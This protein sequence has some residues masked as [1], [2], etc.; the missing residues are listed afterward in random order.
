MQHTAIDWQAS[1]IWGGEAESPRNEW[2][3]FRKSFELS[4]TFDGEASLSITADSR[5]VLYVNGVQAG[6]GPVRSWPFEQSYDTYPVGHLLKPGRTNTLAVLVQH[7]GVSTFYYV[8]GKGGLLAQLEMGNEAGGVAERIGTDRSWRTSRH[9]GQDPRAPRMSCQHAFS[10][11]IDG[12]AWRED[13]HEPDYSDADWAFAVELGKAGTGPWRAL[14]P[15]EIPPLTEQPVYPVRIEAMSRVS[16]LPWTA[17]LELRNQLAPGSEDNANPY[18]YAG[19]AATV[20]RTEA[21]CRAV[22]GFAYVPPH[23]T[24]LILNG[25]RY[26][27]KELRAGKAEHYLHAELRKG[28]N[29]LLLELAGNDHGR[30]IFMGID[31]DAGFRLL[32]PLEDGGLSPFVTLG[33]FECYEYIDHKFSKADR[34]RERIVS[35]CA[36][37]AA[38]LDVLAPEDARKVEQFREAGQAADP[39]ALLQ[40]TSRL[41][42]MPSAFVSPESVMTLSIWKKRNEPLPV[43]SALQLAASAAPVSASIPAF[44]GMD[45]E[46][47]FD[48]GGQT[49]GTVTFEIEAEAG[50]IVDGYGFEHMADGWI[51]HTHYLDNTFRYICRGGRQRFTSMVRRGFRYL[52]VTVRGATKPVKLH[53]LHLIESTYPVPEVGQFQCSDPLLNEIWQI[54]RRTTKLCMEDTFVDC[55]A[56]EQTFWV[57]DARNEAL[58]ANYLFGSEE[59]VRRCLEL[60]PGSREQTPLYVD[61]VPSGWN[62]VIPNWTFFWVMACQEYY[63]RTGDSAFAE[64]MWSHVSF[65]LDHYLQLLDERGLLSMDAWNFLD[66]AP[67]DQPREGVVSHQTMFLVK[68]LRSAAELGET[69]GKGEQAAV[70]REAAE[71]LKEAVNRHLWS[72]EKQAY[73]DCIHTDGRLSSIFSMQTQTVAYLC[74]IAEEERKRTL[75]KYLLESPKDFVPIGSP[76]M[77]FFYYEA[78]ARMGEYRRMLDDMR[79]QYGQMIDYGATT[80]WEMYLKR[81][82]GGE[83]IP[84]ELTRSHCHAWSAAPGYFLGASVLGVQAAE[85]G[86]T[87]VT[88]EPQPAD[89]LWAKGSVPLPGEGRIDVAWRVLRAGHLAIQVTVPGGIEADVRL[90]ARYT[91]TIEVRKLGAAPGTLLQAPAGVSGA[92]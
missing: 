60:V 89:L 77:S 69:A 35:A 4:E 8:R 6:R 14:K 34:E 33:P 10:E 30:G 16:S 92:L 43:P 61:Q 27:E 81:D 52:A 67:I 76:F 23:F 42:P 83:V 85:P 9:L 79:L 78:L 55:P 50:T 38:S 24:G 47:I 84:T 80:C 15:R 41:R 5:Y 75:E 91:G 25:T 45:T 11:R 88:I 31:C 48:F 3:C 20:I 56:Y 58:V 82:A 59:L 13:W 70:Y 65:T 2:H 36:D 62:S 44:E 86:W 18:V 63:V 29:L 54:S 68:A 19:Y 73:L 87:R 28:D 22:I 32:S 49:V 46:L 40:D 1:W 39:T 7:Y 64:S 71:R 53:D 57:G 51:Q 12:R 37:P 26:A 17:N 66:W 90:P 72:E 21:P 74:E